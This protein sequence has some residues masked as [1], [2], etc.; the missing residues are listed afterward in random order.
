MKLDHPVPF[1]NQWRANWIWHGR[2]KLTMRT[3][4]RTALVDPRDR[5]VLFRR[6]IELDEVP[7]WAPARIWVDGRYILYV[8]GHEVARG[9]VR[10]EPRSARY[11]FVDI[12]SSLRVGQNTLAIVARHFGESTSWWVPVPPTYSLGAGSLVFE[13]LVADTW[14]VS[15]DSWRS[16]PGDAWTPVPVPGDV[17]CLPLESFDAREHCWGWTESD[18]DDS[19][20]RSA[21]VITPLHT[22]ADGRKCPPSSPFGA[23]KPPVRRTFPGGLQ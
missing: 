20:W 3:S 11:D 17:A 9:P 7:E 1:G 10:N 13:A 6:T 12:A 19:H 5:V 23:L 16:A 21:F 2:P 15:D 22:G 4:T 14:V 18:F 8:N